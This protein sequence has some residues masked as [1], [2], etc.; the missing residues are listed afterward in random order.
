[1]TKNHKV[2]KPPCYIVD[3]SIH[4]LESESKWM[5]LLSIH[6]NKSNYLRHFRFCIHCTLTISYQNLI[7]ESYRPIIIL[8]LYYLIITGR[9]GGTEFYSGARYCV[10]PLPLLLL[11]LPYI[12]ITLTKVTEFNSGFTAIGLESAKLKSSS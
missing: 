5:V 3:T 9:V 4:R 10:R 1:M 2:T 11:L 8:Y 6:S 7:Y 12:Y